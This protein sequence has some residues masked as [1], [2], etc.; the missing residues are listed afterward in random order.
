MTA[1]FVLLVLGSASVEIAM[2]ICHRAKMKERATVAFN[3]AE[4]AADEAECWLRAQPI[5]PVG[6]GPFD[7]IGGTRELESGTYRALIYP[8]SGNPGAWRK[9]YTIVGT[10]ESAG[11]RVRKQVIVRVQEQS[12]A[13]YSY[14]TDWER[15]SVTNGTIWFYAR[16]RL[17]GPVHSNDQLHISWA[18][19]SADPIFRGTVS[20][21]A[22]SVGWK[23]SAPQSQQDWRRV[24]EGGEDALSLGVD[25]IPLPETTEAQKVAAWGDMMGFPT[26][27]GVYVPAAGNHIKAGIYVKGNC[28]IEF[29]ADK[30]TGDQ[31]VNITQ[32]GETTTV[33]VDL[34]GNRTVVDD[35]GSGPDKSYTGIPNGVLYCTG[36]ITSLSGTIADNYEN[37]SMILERNAWTVATD[38][39]AGKDINITDDLEYETP[40]DSRKPDTHPKNLRA[41]SLGLVADDIV[42]SRKCP[43]NLNIDAVLLANGTLYYQA[44]RWKKRNDLHI[45]GGIIQGRRGPIGTFN[46]W[47]NVH[48]T[49]YNKDYRYDPRMADAPPPFFPTTGQYDVKSW[50]HR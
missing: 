50:Q 40:P 39:A 35:P 32:K 17:Y 14:F 3:L 45:V 18:Y 36:N 4:A 44:W 20:S 26:Q 49:G 15:S 47:N 6:S 34:D 10:G 19:T 2:Q 5:P 24:L 33:T 31:V 41:P 22:D 30:P 29:D 21:A 16:D 7:P 25:P 23:P 38:V 37:G 1:L 27:R 43:N 13:L 11:G 9:G 8:D 28:Q 12:F 42:L 48:V 46:P